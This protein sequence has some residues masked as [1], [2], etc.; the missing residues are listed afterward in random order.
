LTGSRF[1]ALDQRGQHLREVA[2]DLGADL[3]PDPVGGWACDLH[4]VRDARPLPLELLDPMDRPH[5]DLTEVGL[6]DEQLGLDS[7]RD[8]KLDRLIADRVA[9]WVGLWHTT[10]S[11]ETVYWFITGGPV[12]VGRAMTH[13]KPSDPGFY[14]TLLRQAVRFTILIEFLVNVYVFP[15]VTE[16]ILVPIIVLFVGL[17]VV[18]AS[19]PAQAPARKLVDGGLVPLAHLSC[20]RAYSNY[21]PQ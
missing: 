16:L 2:A 18:A 21:H 12:L 6:V 10:A 8:P 5:D 13:A 14:K 3:R 1:G 11:K 17:Q 19:D 9:A 20:S 15:L 4:P 7:L